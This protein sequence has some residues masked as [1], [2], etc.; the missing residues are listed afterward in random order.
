MPHWQNLKKKLRGLQI[1]VVHY[2]QFMVF[3]GVVSNT[4]YSRCNFSC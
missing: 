3:F 4:N 2:T 1:C